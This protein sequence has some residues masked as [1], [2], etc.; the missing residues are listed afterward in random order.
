MKNLI[1]SA[2]MMA[3]IFTS[4]D[5]QTGKTETSTSEHDAVLQQNT[6]ACSMHPEITG[7]KG[8][9]CSKCDMELTAMTHHDA[10]AGHMY[11]CS[12]HPEITGVKGDKCS[13]CG[14]EL[15]EAVKK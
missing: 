2:I 12:M 1:L 13:K 9:K 8:D 7:V 6:H 5:S 4:C 11:A 15:T 10:N 14:M 3:F